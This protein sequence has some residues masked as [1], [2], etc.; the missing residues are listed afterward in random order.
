M[1]TGDVALA[2]LVDEVL[3]FWIER[4]VDSTHGGVMTCLDRDGSILDE[5][6]HA[7]VESV[8]HA[9]ATLAARL[10]RD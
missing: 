7:L 5:K 8:G 2:K 9:V 10:P 4:G 1:M 6:R 3:P